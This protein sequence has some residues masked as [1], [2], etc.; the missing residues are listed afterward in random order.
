MATTLKGI[1]GGGTTFSVSPATVKPKTYYYIAKGSFPWYSIN[2]VN[3]SHVV[4]TD[5]SISGQAT[6]T[7]DSNV[8]SLYQMFQGCNYLKSIDLSNFDTSKVTDMSYMFDNTFF[9]IFASAS[10]D[11]SNFNTSKVTDMSYMFISCRGLITLDLSSFDTSKVW[12]MNGMFKNCISLTT[13]KGIIDMKSCER[14]AEMFKDCSELK[15]VKIK[16]PPSGFNGAGL[17]SSQ[18]TIVS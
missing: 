3:R 14:C 15:D 7:C 9:D 4:S 16:N 13:I 11:F 12:N 5:E 6:V 10:I 2:W 18:Y 8:T 17:S 1:I